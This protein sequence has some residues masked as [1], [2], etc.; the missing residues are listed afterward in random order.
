MTE[1]VTM[2]DFARRHTAESEHSHFGGSFEELCELVRENLDSRVTLSHVHKTE[3]GEEIGCTDG[4]R[5]GNPDQCGGVSKVS[6]PG[7][8]FFTGV[9]QI[10]GETPLKAFFE[11]RQEGEPAYI[12]FR[13]LGGPKT[14]AVEVD[15]ILYSHANLAKKNEQSTDADW[16]IISINAK[17]YHGEEPPHP[18]TMARNFLDLPG[19]TAKDYA[20]EEFAESILHWL[21]GGERAPYVKL[22]QGK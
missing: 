8:G 12:A 14:P 22:D 19:G 20:A 10:D 6:L 9:T 16:E 18:V 7:A 2:N 5:D 17:P 1:T 11:S 13:A 15:I 3:D 4:P 21:G